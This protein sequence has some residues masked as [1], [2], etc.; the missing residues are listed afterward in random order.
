M[1]ATDAILE[2][3]AHAQT[4]G[5]IDRN[6][7]AIIVKSHLKDAGYHIAHTPTQRKLGRRRVLD[8][9]AAAQAEDA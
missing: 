9:L 2:G 5:V 8:A 7:A 3:I 4:L 1:N 6:V